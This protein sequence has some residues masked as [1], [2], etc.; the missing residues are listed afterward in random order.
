MAPLGFRLKYSLKTEMASDKKLNGTFVIQTNEDQYNDEKLIK[1][2]KNLN[3][4]ET[5]FRVIKHDLDLRPMFH[6]KEERVKG[7]VYV[8]VLALFILRQ[9][10]ISQVNHL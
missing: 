2:Y 1:V 7:H 4:V 3:K 6:W 5:A 10:I 8:Y 9:L